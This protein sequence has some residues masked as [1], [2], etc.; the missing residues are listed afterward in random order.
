[1]NRN[2]NYVGYTRVSSI[3]QQKN[4]SLEDQIKVLTEYGVPVENIIV[5][6]AS[7]TNLNLRPKLKEFL[8]KNDQQT[9]IQIRKLK[10]ENIANNAQFVCVYLD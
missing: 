8:E 7:A 2:Q 9:E 5:E 1:M 3:S 4:S 6:T 10:K